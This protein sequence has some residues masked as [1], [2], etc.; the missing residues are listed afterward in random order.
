MAQ[1]GKKKR[2]IVHQDLALNFLAGIK[3]PPIPPSPGYLWLPGL[4]KVAAGSATGFLKVYIA[5]ALWGVGAA[6]PG[7]APPAPPTHDS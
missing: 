6:L 2:H 4:R 7:P 3:V 1:G 5:V